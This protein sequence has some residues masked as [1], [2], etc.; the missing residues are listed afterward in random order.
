M[1]SG[2]PNS[3]TIDF[4]DDDVRRTIET[5][6]VNRKNAYNYETQEPF[7]DNTNKRESNSN[8]E[9]EN[10]RREYLRKST[11]VPLDNPEAL[12][13]AEKVPAYLRRGT[14]L[15][16]DKIH[17]PKGRTSVSIFVDEEGTVVQSGNSFL[18][19]KAD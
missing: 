5:Y 18:T 17:V 15:E 14:K 12:E 4:D 8:D 7:I 9:S 11:T 13:K 3:L 6:G 10:A 2:N 1:D 19:E 16:E